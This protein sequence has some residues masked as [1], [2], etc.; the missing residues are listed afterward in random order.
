MKTAL[1]LLLWC[2]APGQSSV[3]VFTPTGAMI[4]RRR[5]P[6][7][8]HHAILAAGHGRRQRRQRVVRKISADEII[9]TLADF[10]SSTPYVW[11]GVMRRDAG[12]WTFYGPFRT[13][14]F[15]RPSWQSRMSLTIEFETN[16]T[17]TSEEISIKRQ[18]CRRAVL[19]SADPIAQT[20][21][22]ASGLR[23][24]SFGRVSMQSGS[25]CIDWAI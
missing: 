3:G 1:M 18:I 15:S 24:T 17:Q 6:P 10:R 20:Q 11:E 23:E 25:V 5:R 2:A 7:D 22:G 9:R 8:Q 4:R 21:A 16:A 12:K 14:A 19:L 13:V